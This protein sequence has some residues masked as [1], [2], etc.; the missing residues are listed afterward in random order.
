MKTLFF[1]FS[2]LCTSHLTQSIN[3]HIQ[4]QK[5]ISPMFEQNIIKRYSD[6]RKFKNIKQIDVKILQFWE[7]DFVIQNNVVCKSGISFTSSARASNI[8]DVCD[9]GIS[10]LE[11]CM[12][13]SK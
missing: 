5:N 4:S 11:R 12:L 6:L 7:D 2:L 8:F 1:L 10:K 13:L 9:I 3:I